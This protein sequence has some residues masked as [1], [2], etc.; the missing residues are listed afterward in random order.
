MLFPKSSSIHACFLFCSFWFRHRPASP[1]ISATFSDLSHFHWYQVC[2]LNYVQSKT[3]SFFSFIKFSFSSSSIHLILRESLT[4]TVALRAFQNSGHHERGIR[5]I[6]ASILRAFCQSFQKVHLRQCPRR[7][8]HHPFLLFWVSLFVFVS[9]VCWIL[10]F[11]WIYFW[12]SIF[13]VSFV[14]L[15]SRRSKSFLR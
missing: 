2:S 8:Y 5:R 15:Q 10:R 1:A 3:K 9:Q 7:R 13:C 11:S 14:I 4:L 6:R 12:S